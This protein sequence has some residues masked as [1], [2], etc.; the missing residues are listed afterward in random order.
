VTTVVPSGAVSPTLTPERVTHRRRPYAPMAVVMG[1]AGMAIIVALHGSPGWRTARVLLVFAAG[2]VAVAAR[3]AAP[4]QRAVLSMAAAIPLLA[5]GAGIGVPHV[6]A[7]AS[8]VAV[9][10]LAALVSGIVLLA[11]AVTTFWGAVAGWG[12]VGV[13]IALFAVAQWLVFPVAVAVFATNPAPTPAAERT[14]AAVGLDFHDVTLTTEDGVDLAAWH[15]PSRNGAAVLLLHGSGSTRANVLDHAAVLARDGYGVL[16]LDARGHGDSGGHEMDLGWQGDADITPAVAFLVGA[17]DVDD[18]RVGIVGMSM[19]GEEAMGAAAS[20][21]DIRAVVAEGATG[22]TGSDWLALRSRGL[23]RWFSSAFY[24]VQD[25]AA[26]VLSGTDPP[27]DL[28]SAVVASAPRH[29]LVIAAGEVAEEGRA[30]RR[31]Q[32]AAPGR[33]E[34]WEVPDAGHTAGLSTRPD[35]W[36]RRVIAF[37]DRTLLGEPAQEG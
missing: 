31:W 32:A 25:A 22:R 26:T 2:T 9:A 1:C 6:V 8:V 16:L 15:V 10:G 34:L 7:G 27:E 35:E 3:H 18:A 28:R 30:G 37:L 5:T 29:I 11:S 14:P 24:A 4:L 33:V 21:P 19:G 20:N 12:K 36:R 23:G 13:V 17:P